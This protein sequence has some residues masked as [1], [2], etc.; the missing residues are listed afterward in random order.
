MYNAVKDIDQCPF[1]ARQGYKNVPDNGEHRDD[2]RKHNH[3]VHPAKQAAQH[4]AD[5]RLNAVQ[6]QNRRSA[7]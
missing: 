4:I 5:T 3:M 2:H 7:V 1:T 6:T